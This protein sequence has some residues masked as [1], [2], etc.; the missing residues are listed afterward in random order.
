MNDEGKEIVDYLLKL[1][2]Q[3]PEIR[4]YDEPVYQKAKGY[5]VKHFG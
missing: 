2:K 4:Q 1:F 3:K 5:E